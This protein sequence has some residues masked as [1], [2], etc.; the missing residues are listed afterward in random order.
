M[1]VVNIGLSKVQFYFCFREHNN[2]PLKN[3][4]SHE[5]IVITVYILYRS[6]HTCCVEISGHGLTSEQ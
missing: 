6:I 2:Q 1:P 3:A 4:E 5:S